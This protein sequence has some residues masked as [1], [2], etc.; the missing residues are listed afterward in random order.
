[1]G[2]TLLTEEIDP[3]RLHQACQGFLRDFYSDIK[4]FSEHYNVPEDALS[5]MVTDW[6]DFKAIGVNPRSAT[7]LE[8]EVN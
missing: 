8:D 7:Y 1:L 3:L 2:C 6:V 4:V 5:A